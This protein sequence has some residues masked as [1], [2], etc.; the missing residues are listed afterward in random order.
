MT[1]IGAALGWI[2][3]NVIAASLLALCAFMAVRLA[4][5][6]WTEDRSGFD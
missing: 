6:A 1:G 4:I 3:D 5:Q 2:A